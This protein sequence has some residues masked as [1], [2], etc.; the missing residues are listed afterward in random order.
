MLVNIYGHFHAFIQIIYDN[1]VKIDHFNAK[2]PN[3]HYDLGFLVT[4]VPPNFV[5]PLI[6]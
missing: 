1:M 2:N 5:P 3:F 4:N 6:I